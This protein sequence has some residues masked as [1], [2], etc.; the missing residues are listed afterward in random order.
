[1]DESQRLNLEEM[2]KHSDVEDN[3]DKIRKLKHSS[4][5]KEDVE[6]Y[7]KLNKKYER[8][9]K[10]NKKIF[11]QMMITHMNF[12]WT[13]YTNIFNRLIKDEL[14]L[15][16]LSKFISVLSLVE[17]GKL[18]QHDA[19][20]QIGEILKSLYIDSAVKRQEKVD[21]RNDKISKKEKIIKP[22]K[23]ISWADYKARLN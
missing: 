17:D 6:T 20:V 4:K 1:M 15:K 13:N 18:N 2:L 5:I 21:K 3:T 19:S 14:D 10:N 11:N 8:M 22:K 16:I 23:N 12:L 9:K 7:I